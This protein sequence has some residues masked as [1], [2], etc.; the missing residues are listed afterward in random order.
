MGGG[1]G[2]EA[3]GVGAVN[4]VGGGVPDAGGTAGGG[5]TKW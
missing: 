2:V 4:G 5:I 3:G 1:P